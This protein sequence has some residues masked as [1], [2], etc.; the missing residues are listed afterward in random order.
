[1]GTGKLID[2][3]CNE[4]TRLVPML[5]YLFSW[6]RM[7]RAAHEALAKR[8]VQNYYPIQMKEATILAS[9]LLS[10]STGAK[11]EKQFHRVAASTILSI[12]YDYPT[13]DSIDDPTLKKIE[14][15]VL[16]LSH[17]AMPGSYF[18]NIFPWMLHIPER[19]GY[20]PSSHR[21]R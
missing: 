3:S 15:Y 7:R 11:L 2:N 16:R 5:S 10:S 8:A 17:A 19:F 13:L 6:R 14:D 9:S 12:V 20:F 21:V 18:V 1:M 4:V